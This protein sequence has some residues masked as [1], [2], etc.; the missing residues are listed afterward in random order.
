MSLLDQQ[1]S[2]AVTALD[3]QAI[4][5]LLPQVPGWSLLDGKL[6]RSFGF[7]NYHETIAFVNAIAAMIHEQDHHPELRV[8]YKQ[9]AVSYNTH[10]VG[11]AV[12]TND[13]IC[14]AKA[15]AIYQQRAGA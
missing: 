9:C 15:N 5:D 12:S 6:Y 1:C 14:A 8:T 10:S 11:G 4:I 3:A 2:H 7:R 13:F